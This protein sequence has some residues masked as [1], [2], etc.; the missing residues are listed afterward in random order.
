[1][2]RPENM[3]DDQVIEEDFTSEAVNEFEGWIVGHCGSHTWQDDVFKALRR[4][5]ETVVEN[6]AVMVAEIDR[7]RTPLIEV[8]TSESSAAAMLKARAVLRLEVG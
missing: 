3:P 5:Y 6:E 4:S 7:L 8:A 1:M 2:D